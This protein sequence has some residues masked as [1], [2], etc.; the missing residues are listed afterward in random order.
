M[1]GFLVGTSMPSSSRIDGVYHID[2]KQSEAGTATHARNWQIQT[3]LVSG[4]SAAQMGFTA[5]CWP[6]ADCQ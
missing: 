1:G 2:R 3:A 4:S 6:R 5:S